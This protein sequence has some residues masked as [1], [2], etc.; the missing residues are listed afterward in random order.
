MRVKRRIFI[1]ILSAVLGCAALGAALY[2]LRAPLLLALDEE[3]IFLYGIRRGA[4]KRLELSL[5]LFRRVVVA[6]IAEG[7]SPDVVAFAAGAAAARP[8]A[9]LFPG[10]HRQ[11]AQ[12]YAEQAP[13]IPVGVLGGGAIFRPAGNEG[14]RFIE[15]DKKTD[16]YLAGRCAAIFAL[17]GGGGVLFFAGDLI[18]RADRETFEKGLRDQGFADAPVFVDRGTEYA[19]PEGLSCVVMTSPAENFLENASLPVILF[20]WIDPGFTAR[21][22]KII[23]DDSPWALALASARALQEPG[24]LPPAA[25]EVLALWDRIGDPDLRRDLKRALNSG[26]PP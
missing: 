14:F 26:A 16:L 23:F 22:V 25:S 11:G 24:A 17:R 13:E 5:R 21:G 4:L 18:D 15:T 3:F 20:S 2:R 9:A 7:A 6:R 1:A 8:Y 12:R 10:R 19:L